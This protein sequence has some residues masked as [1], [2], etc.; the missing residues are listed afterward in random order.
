MEVS[1]GLLLELANIVHTHISLGTIW[2]HF[3]SK[4]QGM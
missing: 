3:H 1:Y 2:L 4:L